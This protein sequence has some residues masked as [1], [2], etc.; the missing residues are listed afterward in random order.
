[1]E[2]EGLKFNTKKKTNRDSISSSDRLYLQ[3]VF[4]EG[5]EKLKSKYG[6]HFN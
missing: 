2:N 3:E 5:L 6:I 4:R 1:M